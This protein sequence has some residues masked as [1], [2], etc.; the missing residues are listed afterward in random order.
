MIIFKI[1]SKPLFQ[2]SDHYN[3]CSILIFIRKDLLEFLIAI[4]LTI[5]KSSV[6][7]ISNGVIIKLVFLYS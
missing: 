5:V 3:L 4:L 2:D 6:N 1:I 7:K